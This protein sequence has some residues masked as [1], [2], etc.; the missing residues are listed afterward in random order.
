MKNRY[1]RNGFVH[2]VI[3]EK[4]CI[5][6]K[7]DLSGSPCMLLFELLKNRIHSLLNLVRT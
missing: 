4:P 3:Q 7:G 1:K 6:K 2:S 5:Y